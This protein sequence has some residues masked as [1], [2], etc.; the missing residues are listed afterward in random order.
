MLRNRI[1]KGMWLDIF[2]ALF[3]IL[4]LKQTTSSFILL[5]NMQEERQALT[6]EAQKIHLTQ[7]ERE[8]KALIEKEPIDAPIFQVF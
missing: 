6:E 2:S 5:S 8:F 4:V 1:E 7:E 3:E